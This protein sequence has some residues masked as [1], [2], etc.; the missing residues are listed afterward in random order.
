[1]VLSNS[2]Q[3]EFACIWQSK[4]VGVIGIEIERTQIHFLKDVFVA[5]AVVASLGGTLRNHDDDGNGAS[6]NERFNEQNNNSARAL[7]FLYICLP[8]LHNYDVKWPNFKFTWE[9]ERQGDKFYRL[10]P[11][12]SAFPSLQLQPK[13]PSFK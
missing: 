13:S 4:W 7:R 5:V 6:K 12:F 10:C 2:F 11:N 3:K 8:S 9:Q 1:M